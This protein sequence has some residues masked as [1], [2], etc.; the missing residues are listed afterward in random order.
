MRLIV[1]SCHPREEPGLSGVEGVIFFS[2][3]KE[4]QML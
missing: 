4:V 1:N 2:L 3:T